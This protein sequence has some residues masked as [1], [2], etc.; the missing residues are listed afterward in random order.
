M[1]E[2]FADRDLFHIVFYLTETK[3]LKKIKRINAE[4][5]TTKSL[6]EGVEWKFPVQSWDIVSRAL[7]YIL[8]HRKINSDLKPLKSQRFK[9]LHLF[10]IFP[11]IHFFM[12][13]FWQWSN[14]WFS[15]ILPLSTHSITDECRFEQNLHSMKREILNNL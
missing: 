15:F 12:M 1:P 11:K 3:T 10:Y 4:K 6:S 5:L 13:F 7:R 9:S 8:L 2:S 14:V